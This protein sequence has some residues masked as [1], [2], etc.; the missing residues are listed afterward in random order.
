MSGYLRRLVQWVLLLLLSLILA[1]Y[2]EKFAIS[3]QTIVLFLGI[4]VSQWLL[5]L[6]S[7]QEQLYYENLLRMLFESIVLGLYAWLVLWLVTNILH[8]NV[9]P[10]LPVWVWLTVEAIWV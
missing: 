5:R 9:G 8:A 6:G 10:L 3:V 4:G 7:K 2:L 1:L